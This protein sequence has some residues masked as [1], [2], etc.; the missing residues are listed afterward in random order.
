MKKLLSVLLSGCL[1]F[2][3]TAC[4]TNEPPEDTRTPWEKYWAEENTDLGVSVQNG[5]TYLCGSQYNFVGLNCYNLLTVAYSSHKADDSLEMLDNMADRGVTFVRFNLVGHSSRD[6]AEFEQNRQSQL[7]VLERIL[8]RA[9]ER[10]V[11]LLPSFFWL[12]YGLTDYFEEKETAWN[13]QKS[14]T[15]T[16]AM[17]FTDTMFEIMKDH[18]CI[19]GWEF[20]NEY[21]LE[22]DIPNR[23]EISAAD[24]NFAFEK[25]ATK[26]RTADEHG[27]MIT[28]GNAILRKTQYHLYTEKNWTTDTL[29]QKKEITALFHPDP[30]D[31]VSEHIYGLKNGGF[32]V[33]EKNEE[34]KLTY[35][36]YVQMMRGIAT[37]L[38][39]AYFIGEYGFDWYDAS[40]TETDKKTEYRKMTIDGMEA[41]ANIMLIWNYAKGGA[42]AV[43]CSFDENSPLCG[44]IFDLVAEMQ[45]EYAIPK[46][47]E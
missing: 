24:V 11:L 30:M 39:K 32:V 34:V 25:W 6:W 10:H 16:Y 26:V 37:E 27:R 15:F 33:N 2:A 12:S 35:R 43:E 42:E 22:V 23:K 47:A 41:G 19:A 46:T 20:G 13:D 17:N 38:N 44:Y 18:K 3:L 40:L 8:D 31:V 1:L 9:D 21:N 36:E 7:D 28:S 14:K 4:R 29:E 5:N 45:A